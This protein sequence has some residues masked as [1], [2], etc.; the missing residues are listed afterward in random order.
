MSRTPAYSHLSATPQPLR[1]L[2]DRQ[3]TVAPRR[4]TVGPEAVQQGTAGGGG[5][6]DQEQLSHE[7]PPHW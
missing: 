2:P 7:T 1:Y 5:Q 6:Q 4:G 3:A